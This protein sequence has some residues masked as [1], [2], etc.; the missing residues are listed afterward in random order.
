ME[1]SIPK[2]EEDD[3]VYASE[4]KALHDIIAKGLS[5]P[6]E[7]TAIMSDI[8]PE[9][10]DIVVACWK[11]AESCW[12]A[13]SIEQ[14]KRAKVL[15]EKPV[16][17]ENTGMEHVGTV[18]FAIVV[19]QTM[20]DD[21]MV[22]LRDWK[23][24]HGWVPPARWNLQLLSYA[25]G[26]AYQ[27]GIDGVANIG[28]MQPLARD[29]AD[30]WVASK[31]DL[32][33]VAHKIQKV[34][35]SCLDENAPCIPGYHCQYCRAA[36]KCESRLI[37]STEVKSIASPVDA[38]HALTPEN[39]T[40]FYEKLVDAIGMLEDA[41]TTIN[42]AII[43]GELVV[44]GYGKKDGKKGR[45]WLSDS[46][47]KIKEIATQKGIP[48]SDVYEMIS[49]SKAEKLLGKKEISGLYGVKAGNQTVGRIAA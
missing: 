11:E 41:K 27:N 23:T 30:T 45:F 21:G 37:A 16:S 2:T 36:R 49:P 31:A 17:L 14:R 25:S 34:V 9:H 48:I 46:E 43:S 4:G 7:R 39:R 38:I 24:G 28:I 18:D 5:S 35:A 32:D 3:S 44:A 26:L 19:E 47:Q 42:E 40:A 22:V 8:E 1:A 13:L 15:I 29:Y 20:T 10:H 12:S 6:A 33:V